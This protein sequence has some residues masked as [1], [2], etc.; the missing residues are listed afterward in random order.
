MSSYKKF[1]KDVG[2]IA[3]V[4]FLVVIKGII[5][6]PLITKLLGAFEYGIWTQLLITVSLLTPLIRMGL[7]A[8]LVRYLAAEKNKEESQEGI[9]STIFLITIISLVFTLLFLIFANPISKFFQ[10]PVILITILPLIILFECLNSVFFS[11][12][13]AYQEMI[14]YSLFMM[15]TSFGE[16]VLV[17][18]SVFSG[19]GLTGATFSLLFIRIFVFVLLFIAVYKKIGFKIPNFSPIKKYLY[20]GLPSVLSGFSYLIVT[21]SDKYLVGFFQGTLF[22]GYYA[23]AYSLGN[24]I[25]FLIIPLSFVLFP[26]VCKAYD[27]NKMDVVKNK[28]KYSLKYFLMIAIPSV[29]GLSVLTKEL[30]KVFSTNDIMV[31]AFFVTP[32]IA[33]SILF[34]GTS[35]IFAQIL[36]LVKKTKIVGYI[37]TFCAFLNIVLN[38]CLIPNFGILG[39]AISTLLSYIVAFVLAWY[40]SCKEFTFEIDWISILKSLSAAFLMAILVFTINPK[41]LLTTIVTVV[42][43][44]IFYSILIILTKGF[45]KKE[46]IF[47]KNILKPD[48]MIAE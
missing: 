41:G 27:E 30:L 10:A 28:L 44:I 37:W 48:E 14:K 29:F 43:G 25:T 31:H 12:F 45:T 42:I 3:V 2:I 16:I 40:Y 36:T 24:V 39:A 6:I 26:A 13:Q 18:A 15:L 11:L 33:L 5:F 17:V 46:F 38:L 23:P 1:T 19:Y 34:Y 21:S 7:T 8:S 47:L 35:D 9:Y 20:F 32:F 22:V 4:N